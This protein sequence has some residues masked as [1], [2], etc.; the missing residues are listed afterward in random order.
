VVCSCISLSWRRTASNLVKLF[1]IVVTPGTRMRYMHAY[2]GR[3]QVEGICVRMSSYG[4]QAMFC[5]IA[6]PALH[7]QPDCIACA[8]A[9]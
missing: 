6:R 7:A 1:Q 8:P 5:R 9:T 2:Y 4:V 3:S